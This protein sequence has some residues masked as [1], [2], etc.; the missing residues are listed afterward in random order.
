MPQTVKG[1][2]A[3]KQGEP[4]TIENIVIPD[5]G[6]GEAVVA[7]KA[8]EELTINYN[9]KGGGPV[10]DDDNWFERHEVEPI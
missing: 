8:G 2:V 5:P 4:V 9:T 7:I 10:S 1:V 3:M 6:P